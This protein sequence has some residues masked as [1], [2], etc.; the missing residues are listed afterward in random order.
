MISAKDQHGQLLIV[1]NDGPSILEIMVEMNPDRYVLSP[2]DRMEISAALNGAPFHINAYAGGLQIY[3]GN[4][5]GPP[6]KINGIPAK[7]WS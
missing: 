1:Q 4:D 7:P 5:V 6:V 3:P 2:G